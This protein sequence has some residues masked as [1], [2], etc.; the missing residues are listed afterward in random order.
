VGEVTTPAR[1]PDAQ[2]SLTT[3]GAAETRGLGERLGRLLRAGDFVG[4]VGDLGAGKTELVRG[5]ADGVGV[6]RTQVASPTFAIVYPYEGGRIPLHHADLY[7]LADHDELYATGFFHL[8]EEGQGATLV[9]W[10]DKVWS[11]APPE[12]LLLRLAQGPSPEARTLVAEAWG[13][14][15]VPLLESWLPASSSKGHR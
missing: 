13:A 2:R 12:L 15:Y 1:A 5:V 14:R 10:I 7:R 8:V 11:A 4:L 3:H 9:E 6:D